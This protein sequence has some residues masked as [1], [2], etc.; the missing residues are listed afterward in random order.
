MRQ[1]A[2]Y[3]K[4]GIGKSTTS[5]NLSAA[6]ADKGLDVLQIG[7]DPKHDSTRMLMN[8]RVIPTV[9]DLIREHKTDLT[10]S[11]VIYPGYSGVRCVEAGGPEP[12][13]GCAGRGIIATFQLLEKLGALRGDLI[14]YDVLG[15]V[16][17]G[18]FAMPMREGYAEE[19]YLV[20]SGELMSLYAANNIAKAI[21]RLSANKRSKVRLAGV[22]GNGK[23]I[24]CEDE[25]VA[26]FA[27]SIGSRM[28][29]FITRSKTVTQAELNKKTVIE[30]APVSSQAEV[31]RGCAEAILLNTEFSIPTPLSIDDLES[32]AYR[33]LKE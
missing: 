15:D 7:C 3:G 29:A 16:V 2:L 5:A 12:G 13:I 32:L 1:I 31:Y 25:L 28:I 14:V 30:Y 20:T 10:V 17:C 22:I 19:V 8:G 23:N 21:S 18:G 6:W 11:D 27:D 9:L 4:G 24:E 26:E 33:Y